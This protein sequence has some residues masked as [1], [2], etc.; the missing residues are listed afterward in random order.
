MNRET[1]Y[2]FFGHRH[3]EFSLSVAPENLFEKFPCTFSTTFTVSLA[4]SINQ[5]T[6]R[7]RIHFAENEEKLKMIREIYL[8]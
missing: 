3:V 2:L 5:A 7:E 1:P 6:N 4:T 8:F